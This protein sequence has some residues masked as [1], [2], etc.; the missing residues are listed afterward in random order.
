MDIV[1]VAE[2]TGDDVAK[3]LGRETKEPAKERT[4]DDDIL[5][6]TFH[7]VR[8]AKEYKDGLDALRVLLSFMK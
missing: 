5:E 1:D 7:E 6:L 8:S 3:A 4:V 2:I